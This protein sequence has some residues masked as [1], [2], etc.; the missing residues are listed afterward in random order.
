ML[1]QM[2]I[3]IPLWITQFITIVVLASSNSSQLP[4]FLIFLWGLMFVVMLVTIP[5][6]VSLAVRRMHDLNKS[7]WWVLLFTVGGMIPII[8]LAAMVCVIYFYFLKQGDIEENKYGLPSI[9]Y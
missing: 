7:G 6:W 8:N 5:A 1:V 9:N 2:I 3:F 4:V